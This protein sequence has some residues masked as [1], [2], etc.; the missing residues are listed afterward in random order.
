MH[1][2]WTKLLQGVNEELIMGEYCRIFI[3][4][5]PEMIDRF[6]GA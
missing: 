6:I 1:F 5:A 4:H 2:F 3:D